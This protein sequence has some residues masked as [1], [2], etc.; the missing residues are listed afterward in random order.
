MSKDTNL[1]V[2]V[3][4]KSGFTLIELLVV[5]AIIGVLSSIVL[6][7]LNSARNKG[8]DAKTKAQLSGLRAAMELYY[9][10]NGS[11]GT[12]TNSCN[13]AFDDNIVAT[14][15]N[16]MSSGVTVKCVS[17]GTGYAVSANLLSVS[18]AD[19]NWCVDSSGTSRAQDNTQPNGDDTCN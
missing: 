3:L 18:G 17:T 2:R 16:N 19:D 1:Y 4:T 15:T 9:D 12:A 7:S 8:N 11:Y 10:N 14:Y 13:N 6:A 5:I